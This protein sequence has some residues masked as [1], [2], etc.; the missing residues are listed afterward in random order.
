MA[1][2][3]SLFFFAVL[4]L[5]QEKNHANL[6][7]LQSREPIVPSKPNKQTHIQMDTQT[8]SC[9]QPQALQLVVL[10]Q[11]PLSC[12]HCKCVIVFF[13]LEVEGCVCWG[14]MFLST[15]RHICNSK[16]PLVIFLVLS[17]KIALFLCARIME[18]KKQTWFNI[19]FIFL[20][21]L[22]HLYARIV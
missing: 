1:D 12:L 15:Y 6:L 20:I 22:K 10:K 9:F 18:P 7:F 16:I 17:F 3:V 2:V 8:Y 11:L 13:F 19:F 21:N 14:Q 5:E 4:S